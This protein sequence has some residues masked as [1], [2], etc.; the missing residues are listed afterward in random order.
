MTVLG[1]FAACP[2]NAVCIRPLAPCSRM[3]AP[4]CR[5]RRLCALCVS[6]F[7]SIQSA[8]DPH[9]SSPYRTPLSL[10]F[11]SSFGGTTAHTPPSSSAPSYFLSF[12]FHTLACAGSTPCPTLS[13]Q[14]EPSVYPIYA[15]STSGVLRAT[16]VHHYKIPLVLALLLHP[17]SPCI[18]SRAMKSSRHPRN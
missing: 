9:A 3:A 11:L 12:N 4:S 14:R 2:A 1:H 8:L 18:R 15:A 7:P 6:P 13:P 17:H 16:P 10:S 5:T